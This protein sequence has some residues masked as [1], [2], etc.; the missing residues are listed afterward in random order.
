MS[1][2]RKV[3][4]TKTRIIHKTGVLFKSEVKVS[5]KNIEIGGKFEL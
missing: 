5:E 4:E 1:H 3:R 2:D